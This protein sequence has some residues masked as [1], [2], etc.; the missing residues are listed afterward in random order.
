MTILPNQHSTLMADTS[1]TIHPVTQDSR[2][3]CPPSSGTLSAMGMESLSAI[4]GMRS[5]SQS[6]A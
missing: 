4:S 3:S 2:A 5:R 6:K 1:A